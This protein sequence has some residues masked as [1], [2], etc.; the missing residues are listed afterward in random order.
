MIQLLVYPETWVTHGL[1]A[2]CFLALIRWG[3]GALLLDRPLGLD[4]PT[5]VLG[6]KPGTL[7]RSA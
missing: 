4:G 3:P 1:W 6:T 2:A 5:T 7:T